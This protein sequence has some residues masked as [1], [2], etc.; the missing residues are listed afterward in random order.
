[1]SGLNRPSGRG[2]EERLSLQRENTQI[3]LKREIALLVLWKRMPLMI[4]SIPY[5]EALPQ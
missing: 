2:K 1:M 4:I 3:H 5:V